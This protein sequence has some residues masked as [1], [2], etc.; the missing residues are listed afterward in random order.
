MAEAAVRACAV[1]KRFGSSPP[2]L[3]DVSLSVQ[4]G[5]ITTLAGSNGSGKSTLLRCIA[6]LTR[7]AGTIEVCGRPVDG[8]IPS[9]RSIGYLPQSVTLPHHAT[10][11]E[12]LALFARLRGLDPATMPMPDGFLRH[13]DTRVGTLSGGQKQRVAL[14][15]SMLGRPEVLLLDEPVANLDEDGRATFWK[16]LRELSADGTSALIASPSPAD[17]AG[18]GDR[19]IVLREGRIVEDTATPNGDPADG[20][21]EPG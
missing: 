16:V 20:R 18:V 4:A 15:I 8:S 1:S 9:R 14:A 17:L 13:G 12:A 5:S 2:V 19:F 11:D 3:D 6:G 7:F 10:I 21:E